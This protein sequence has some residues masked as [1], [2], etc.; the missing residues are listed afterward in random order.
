M[1]RWL[2]LIG[3]LAVSAGAIVFSQK[4]KSATPVGPQAMINLVADTERE[5]SR[6]PMKLT[7]LSDEQEI[8]IGDGMAQSYERSV[9][10]AGWTQKDAAVE[11]Y[12]QRIGI[13]V[14]GRAR[15]KLPYRFHYIPDK[16][17]VNAFALPGG[18][19]FIGKGML[20]L[21]DSEDQLAAV[22]GHE[23]EHVDHYHCAER[24]QV[25]ARLRHLPLGEAVA[26]PVML[27]QAGY[28]KEQEME[29]DRDGTELAVMAGYSPEGI[30]RLFDKFGALNRQIAKD[31]SSPQQELSKTAIAALLDYFRTH[32]LPGERKQ[33]IERLMRSQRWPLRQ[34]TPLVV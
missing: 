14:S 8:R 28:T 23:V 7:R 30:L 26:L 27:F 31:S 33:Q 15:R 5:L 29:A 2:A 12:V 6:V 21:M 3:I 32:P 1:K 20:M 4:R 34:E 22:L 16:Y 25:E 13:K 10:S 17:F 9:K 18:H 11:A 19:V 24:V